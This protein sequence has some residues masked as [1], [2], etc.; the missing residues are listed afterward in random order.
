MNIPAKKPDQ[1]A[2]IENV[3]VRGDLKDLSEDQRTQYYLQVCNS[4]GLNP[5][6]RP[7]DY[8]TLNGKL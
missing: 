5:A 8:L 6:T 7:F 3:L 1:A 2:T 4:L